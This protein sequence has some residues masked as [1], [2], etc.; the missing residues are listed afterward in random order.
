MSDAIQKP[1]HTCIDRVLPKEMED[2]AQLAAILVASLDM[3]KNLGMHSV[4]EGIED[5]EDW[6]FLRQC[7][8]EIAQGYFIARPMPMVALADWLPEW[9]QRRRDMGLVKLKT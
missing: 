2:D 6:N 8:C 5:V 9:E 7:G 4:A 1:I 3:A